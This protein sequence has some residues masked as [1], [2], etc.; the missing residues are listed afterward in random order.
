MSR[1]VSSSMS[2]AIRTRSNDE[3][4]LLSIAVLIP[5]G[6]IPIIAAS[7]STTSG[8]NC[9]GRS[10]GR[11]FTANIGTFVTSGRPARS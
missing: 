11:I 4:G 7:R 1:A 10:A 6:S 9:A 8:R 2:S 3:P 5:A